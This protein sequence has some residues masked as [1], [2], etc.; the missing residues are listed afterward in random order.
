MTHSLSEYLISCF[1]DEAVEFC[2]YIVELIVI[3]F[4]LRVFSDNPAYCS[5]L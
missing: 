3:W 2:V 5:W 1:R 4:L